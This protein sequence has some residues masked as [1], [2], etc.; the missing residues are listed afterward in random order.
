MQSTE[1]LSTA[2]VRD[3]PSAHSGDRWLLQGVFY[4]GLLA[5]VW[6]LIRPRLI[7]DAFGIY[8]PYPEFVLDGACWRQA[9]ASP[10][11]MVEYVAAFLS[12]WFFAASVG[13]LI[14]T[15]AAGLICFGTERLMGDMGSMGGLGATR[16]WFLSLLP[17][18]G[19]LVA[20]LVSG[21]AADGALLM[22]AFGLGTLPNLLLAGETLDIAAVAQ[23]C[24]GGDPDAIDSIVP[25]AYG[26]LA[27]DL[28][29]KGIHGRLVVLR[30]GRYDNMPVDVV[31][32]TKKVVNVNKYYNTERLRPYFHTFEMN[33]LFIMTSD[34]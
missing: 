17:A 27:L 10:G 2:R 14:V 8:L 28:L 5:Y 19:V 9:L 23:R 24:R 4:A 26:N 18:L 16:G 7:Y 32:S 6:F 3:R 15:A 22:L 1:E 25:M 31:T 12:Q 13:A 34:G 11:G 29:L 21:S 30:N 33:P 20:A